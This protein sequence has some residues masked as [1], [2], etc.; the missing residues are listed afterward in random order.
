[1]LIRRLVLAFVVLWAAVWMFGMLRGEQWSAETEQ[2]VRILGREVSIG[3]SVRV[4]RLSA[5]EPHP[6][7]SADPLPA[8]TLPGMRP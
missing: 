8:D 1:M 2:S 4:G 7:S 6:F 5:P 3:L